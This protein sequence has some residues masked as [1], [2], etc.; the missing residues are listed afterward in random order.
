M[1]VEKSI[2]HVFEMQVVPDHFGGIGVPND[3]RAPPA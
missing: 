3:G 1:L 2:S